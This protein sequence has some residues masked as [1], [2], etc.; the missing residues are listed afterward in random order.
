M[1]IITPQLPYRLTTIDDTIFHDICFL[2]RFTV[3]GFCLP[4]FGFIVVRG[5]RT[6]RSSVL[7]P[8][9]SIPYTSDDDT[10]DVIRGVCSSS[11]SLV[12]PPQQS[13]SEGITATILMLLVRLV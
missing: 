11:Q 3:G 5:S 1:H 9:V 6:K 2:S 12:T 13:S 7:P 8:L 10:F 4:L